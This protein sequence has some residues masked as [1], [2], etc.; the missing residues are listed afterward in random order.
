MDTLHDELKVIY[1][2]VRDILTI[3][4]KLHQVH[5]AVDELKRDMK[6]VKAEIT[7]LSREQ[8]GLDRRVTRLESAQTMRSS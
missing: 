3:K 1:E 4:K 7:D 5:E 6:V 2:L 8:H